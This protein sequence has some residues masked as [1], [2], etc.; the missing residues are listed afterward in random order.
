MNHM[1]INHMSKYIKSMDKP[2]GIKKKL[3]KKKEYNIL[4]PLIQY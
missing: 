4:Y 2:F 3:V 1:S